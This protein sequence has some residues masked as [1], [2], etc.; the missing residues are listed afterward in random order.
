MALRG[1]SKK[2]SPSSFCLQHPQDPS[3]LLPLRSFTPFGTESLCLGGLEGVFPRSRSAKWYGPSV[4]YGHLAEMFFTSFHM[5][6]NN[7]FDWMD[8]NTC[9]CSLQCG[10]FNDFNFDEVGGSWGTDG[11]ACNDDNLVSNRGNAQLL[12]NPL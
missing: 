9:R 3:T 10:L 1:G 7:L 8:F 6:I 5:V 11:N 12:W 2:D 4:V